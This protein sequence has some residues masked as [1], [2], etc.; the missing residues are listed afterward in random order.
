MSEAP[1]LKALMEYRQADE[2][3]IMVLVS[4]QAIHEVA[5]LY[6]AQQAE[7]D[8]LREALERIDKHEITRKTTMME[9]LQNI[10]HIA[11]TALNKGPD[12]GE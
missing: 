8:R 1:A 7:I 12:G 10:A 9:R 5:D 11:R 4:R 3:G 6:T 2:E